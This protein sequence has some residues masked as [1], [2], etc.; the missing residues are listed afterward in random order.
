MKEMKITNYTTKDWLKQMGCMLC[1]IFLGQWAFR[2]FIEGDWFHGLLHS[3]GAIGWML[4][5]LYINKSI[6]RKNPREVV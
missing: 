2:A 1:F 5:Y 6:E 4:I 3:L